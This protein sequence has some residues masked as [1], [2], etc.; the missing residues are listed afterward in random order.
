METKDHHIPSQIAELKGLK[1]SPNNE[2]A[3]ISCK[4]KI[5]INH[6][7]I[8]FVGRR[9]SLIFEIYQTDG[10][11]FFR[12]KVFVFRK[13]SYNIFEDRLL[14]PLTDISILIQASL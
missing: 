6:Y 2:S 7:Y 8:D 14:V 9:F 11:Y 1:A 10:E 5:I 12:Y 4:K 13:K 3:T